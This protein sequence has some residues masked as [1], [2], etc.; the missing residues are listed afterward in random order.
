MLLIP[1]PQLSRKVVGFML[2]SI[3]ALFAFH[4]LAQGHFF[5]SLSREV[6]M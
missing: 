5:A 6:A 2:G 3:P 4:F 1:F